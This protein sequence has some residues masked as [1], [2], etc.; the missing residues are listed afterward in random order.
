LV[1]IFCP[2]IYRRLGSSGLQGFEVIKGA[3]VGSLA[4]SVGGID[5]HAVK[6]RVDDI[7][8][9]L[10][11]RESEVGGDRDVLCLMG[12]GERL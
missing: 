9:I 10:A 1:G 4:N 2:V 8:G 6:D 11:E 12:E 3:D 5:V 7:G